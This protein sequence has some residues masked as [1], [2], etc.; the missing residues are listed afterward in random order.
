MNRDKAEQMGLTNYPITPEPVPDDA[1][2]R[3][4]L[5]AC[6][7]T[8]TPHPAPARDLYTGN[9]FRAARRHV[10]AERYDAWW[11]LS[12]RHGLVHPDDILEPY[13]AQMA[14]RT[15]EELRQWANIVDGAF[16]C[17]R[18]GY[19]QWTQAGGELQVD[20]YAGAAYVEPLLARWTHLSWHIEVPHHGLQIGERL[21]A[22]AGSAAA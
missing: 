20:I 2:L 14:G 17:H 1:R 8:K 5:I 22:F 9:L 18:P 12:A 10:E 19:G 3:L 15:N 11:I 16:R 4:A 13:E 7:K 6:G 21:A